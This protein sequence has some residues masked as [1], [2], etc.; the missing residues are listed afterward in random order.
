[1]PEIIYLIS[2]E[3]KIVERNNEHHLKRSKDEISDY[4][5]M[6]VKFFFLC[7]RYLFAI[8]LRNKDFTFFQH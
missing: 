3:K 5:N 2:Q 7:R 1:M 8:W 6:V 4:H